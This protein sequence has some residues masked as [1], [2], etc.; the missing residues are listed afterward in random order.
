[1]KFDIGIHYKKL[2]RKYEFREN[3]VSDFTKGSKQIYTFTFQLSYQIWVNLGQK[4]P[5][6]VAEQM[7]ALQNSEQ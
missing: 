6:N 2:L 3:Q 5:R 7:R 4:F 1:V